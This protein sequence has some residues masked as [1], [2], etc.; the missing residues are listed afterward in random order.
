M[1]EITLSSLHRELADCEREKAT[2]QRS[3]AT[4]EARAHRLLVELEKLKE[5]G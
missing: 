1:A 5:K 4:E 2:A 3:L